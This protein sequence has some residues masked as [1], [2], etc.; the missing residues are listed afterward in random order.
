MQG[1]SWHLRYLWRFWSKTKCE[2]LYDEFYQW[3]LDKQIVERIRLLDS[4]VFSERN[5]SDFLRNTSDKKRIGKDNEEASSSSE[6]RIR[7]EE[8]NVPSEPLFMV[9]GPCTVICYQHHL[10]LVQRSRR[11]RSIWLWWWNFRCQGYEF[12]D[13]RGKK[14]LLFTYFYWLIRSYWSLRSNM[15][16]RADSF[17]I[18][19]RVKLKKFL[20]RKLYKL[21]VLYLM[22]VM[23]LNFWTLISCL[24]LFA[25]WLK[26]NSKIN[27]IRR[28]IQT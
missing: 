11:R 19:N 27:S 13:W 8:I 26:G 14:Y 3:H 24:P 7:L 4:T 1:S 23:T 5:F 12:L 16:W 25:S 6:K 28:L 10:F 18:S 2:D 15:L 20:N 22:R 9:H 21:K 17:V